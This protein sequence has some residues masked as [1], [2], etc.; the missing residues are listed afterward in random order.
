VLALGVLLGT[1]APAGAQQATPSVS[2]TSGDFAGRVDIGGRSLYLECRG[3]GSPT[4]VLEAGAGNDADTWDT[5]GL[6]PGVDGP[7]VLPAVA[8]FTRVCAY[9]RPGTLLDLD[10]RSRSAPVPMPRTAQDVATDLH[11]LLQAADLTGPCVLVGHS[12]GGMVMRLYASDFPADVA[13]LVLVDAAEEGFYELLTGPATPAQRA[14]FSGT[15]SPA[16]ELQAAYP[17][18]ERL[19][20]IASAAQARQE[21]A[22]SPLRPMPLVVLSHG[23]GP[24]D[25]GDLI[26]PWSSAELEQPWQDAQQRLAGLVPGG[27]FILATQSGHFIQG[28][29]PELVIDAIRDVVAPVHAGD[30]APSQLP[31]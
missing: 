28:E 30:R 16:P 27:T 2:A 1:A 7:A 9:D 25:F 12:F 15:S 22:T 14:A 4:V 23:Q 13:G 20:I 5:Q 26:A 17:D 3:S 21:T 31:G 18:S 6:E 8:T 11:A 10:H 29:Q 24:L 19:D